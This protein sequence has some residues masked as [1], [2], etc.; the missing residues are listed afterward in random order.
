MNVS[1]PSDRSPSG[2]A[3]IDPTDITTYTSQAKPLLPLPVFSFLDKGLSPLSRTI[4]DLGKSGKTSVKSNE[5]QQNESITEK[6]D[7]QRSKTFSHSL[8]NN[9]VYISE[10]FSSRSRGIAPIPLSDVASNLL[11]ELTAF[12]KDAESEVISNNRNHPLT[13]NKRKRG[14]SADPSEWQKEE[15]EISHSVSGSANA[16]PSAFERLF[17]DFIPAKVETKDEF[18]VIQKRKRLRN[19]P[20]KNQISKK[21]P[22]IISG[23]QIE[24]NGVFYPI[25]Q[26]GAGHNHRIFA[27]ECDTVIIINQ[28]E[29]PLNKVILR[30]FLPCLDLKKIR[31]NEENNYIAYNNFLSNNIPMPICYLKANEFIDSHNSKSGGFWLLEK[32]AK[33]VTLDGWKEGQPYSELMQE[34]KQVLE[35]VHHW[36]KQS[37]EKKCVLVPT[38]YDR[39]IMWD[40]NDQLKLVDFAISQ[41]LFKGGLDWREELEIFICH[42]SAGNQSVEEYLRT[43]VV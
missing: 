40:E 14:G 9:T 30:T 23:S 3:K 19:L 8:P 35:F 6:L 1:Y 17:A 7:Y 16:N 4:I 43:A 12:Q 31:T 10:T 20:D 25:K 36:L 38:L 42:W 2:Q 28:K 34:D 22:Q 32:M 11:L 21:E 33:S 18:P 39:N 15:T 37:F 29:I 41:G 24:I 26:I 27:F 5:P 13:L